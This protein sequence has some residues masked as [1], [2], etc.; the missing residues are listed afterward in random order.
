MS[1]L[2]Q[3]KDDVKRLSKADQKALLDWLTNV[4]EDELEL[5]DEFKAEIERGEADLAAGHVRI[6]ESDLTRK[7]RLEKFFTEWDATH[8]VS[9]GENPNRERTYSED[10]P[11]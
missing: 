3:I 1:K 11:S 7:E 9:V 2:E 10:K 5:T 8:S 4:L 6:V